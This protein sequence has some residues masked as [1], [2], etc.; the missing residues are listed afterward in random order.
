MKT[1]SSKQKQ[2]TWYDIVPPR[3]QYAGIYYIAVD[4]YLVYIGKSNNMRRRIS[5]HIRLINH[6]TRSNEKKYNYLHQKKNN[7]YQIQFG[8]LA[9]VP[10]EKIGVKEAQLINQYLPILNKQVPQLD[11]YTKCHANP[12]YMGTIKYKVLRIYRNGVD[13][14]QPI[15]ECEKC[16]NVREVKT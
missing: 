4:N 1:S 16:E 13:Q 9:Y 2:L 6:P 11:N 15:K 8:V 10:E 14:V 12:N 3:Y 5:Q 7:G